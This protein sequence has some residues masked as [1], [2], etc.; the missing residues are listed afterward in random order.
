MN[1]YEYWKAQR[2]STANAGDAKCFYAYDERMLEH[3]KTGGHPECPARI[4]SIYGY[5]KENGF[6]DKASQL[7]VVESEVHICEDGTS[8]YPAIERVM[9]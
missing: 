5:L 2:Q 9:T 8:R 6:L 7:E 3:K 1:F 4:E